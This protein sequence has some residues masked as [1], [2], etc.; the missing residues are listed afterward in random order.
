LDLNFTA[1]HAVS[2]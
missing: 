1:Q 2:C